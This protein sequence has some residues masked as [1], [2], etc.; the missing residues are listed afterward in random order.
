MNSHYLIFTLVVSLGVLSFS[1][2][3][4][5]SL[6]VSGKYG[7]CGGSDVKEANQT[8]LQINEDHSFHYFDNSNPDK[9]IDLKGRWKLKGTTVH[10]SDYSSDFGIHNKWTIDKNTKCLKSRKGLNF[11]RLSQIQ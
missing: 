7:I 8:F 2:L 10:L 9:K 1:S 6:S 11:T 5:D 3:E 4:K